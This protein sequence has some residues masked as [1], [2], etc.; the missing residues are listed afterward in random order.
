MTTTTKYRDR[1]IALRDRARHAGTPAAEAETALE[2]ARKLCIKHDIDLAILDAK[3]EP[4]RVAD[5]LGFGTYVKKYPCRFGC[6]M[7][8][9]HTIEELNECAARARARGE[10]PYAA[11]SQRASQERGYSA[12]SRYSWFDDFM[13]DANARARGGSSEQYTDSRGR[14]R[15]HQARATGSHAFCDHPATKSARAKCRKERG[16]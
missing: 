14:T 4:Q 15:T 3:P 11:A 2:M 12:N 16:Y 13:R 10:D 6:G 8:V 1:V 9:Q 7:Y 5:P